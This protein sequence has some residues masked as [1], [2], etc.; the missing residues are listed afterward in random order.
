MALEHSQHL[1]LQQTLS[2]Q[3]RQS[4]AVLQ[5]PLPELEAIVHAELARNP[6]LEEEPVEDDAPAAGEIE[7]S[8]D[9][10]EEPMLA[11]AIHGPWTAEEMER[12]DRFLESKAKPP[13]LADHLR[14]QAGDLRG[15]QREAF[16]VIL[17]SLDADGYFRGR[18]EEA[19]Y[20][21]GLTVGEAEQVLR[22]VQSLDPPGVGARDLRECLLLQLE[23]QG[24]G[25]SLEARIVR[26]H[27]EDLARHKF[28]EIAKSL[29]V[30]LEEVRE[31][32]ETIR[33]LHPRPGR[34]FDHE[35]PPEI[36]P[37]VIV[38]RGEEG[39]F[40]VR[41]NEE[42]FPRLRLSGEFMDLVGV[43]G[44]S[45]EA[46]DFVREKLR[47]G[48]FFLDCLEQRKATVLAVAE[49]I[50][51]RQRGFF[52]EGPL[53]LQPLTMA[54]VAGDVGVHETTVSRAVAGKYMLTP[55]GLFEMRHFFRGGFVREDGE[56][57]SNESVRHMIAEMVKAEDPSHPLSDQE[58]VEALAGRGVKVARRTVAKYRD[59]LAI[60]PSHARKRA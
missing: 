28:H 50:V 26:E 41:L 52:E 23:R 44:G 27:L 2:P 36:A 25:Q 10:L 14:A 11:Y 9:G 37:E 20:P 13:S 46:R 56:A 60:P 18:L 8:G 58:L 7:R 32:A 40:R 45:R 24:R 31:A 51:R 3:M 33:H 38:E 15:P 53:R 16:E 29:G 12:R 55:H 35:D 1:A 43:L 48:R 59:Q 30:S 57:V 47:E 42:R 5:A 39:D 49:A 17:G 54:E 22:F 6:A 4:L 21:Y 34:A 19:A